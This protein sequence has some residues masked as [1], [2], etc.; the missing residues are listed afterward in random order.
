MNNTLKKISIVIP[1]FNEQGNIKKLING[2]IY[3]LELI[4]NLEYQIICVNDLSTDNS[5]EILLDLE[6]N[7]D[8]FNMINHKKNLGQS[9]ALLTGINEAK[10]NQIITMD[11][12]GQNDPADIKLLIDHY[13][14]DAN[15]KLLGGIRINRKDNYIKIISSRIANNFRKFVL[16]DNCNDTG[17]SLKIFDKECFL[18]FPF[19]NGIHRFLPALF[20][21]YGYKT[22]FIDVNHKKRLFGKSKYGTL[23]RLIAGIIDIIRVL[24]ILK[25]IKNG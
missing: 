17:C 6:K 7:I 3:N 21:G 10:Y 8:N 23:K 14:N 16:N 4:K 15:L 22:H 25:N 1:V 24:I 13:F 2:I 11:G 20:K 18:L 9:R 12:D 19:F 5:K